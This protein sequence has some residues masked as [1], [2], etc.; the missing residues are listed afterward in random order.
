MVTLWTP[1][2]RST[3]GVVEPTKDS[4]TL[5]NR[6]NVFIRHL[7]NEKKSQESVTGSLG[8]SDLK[9]II[10]LIFTSLRWLIKTVSFDLARASALFDSSSKNIQSRMLDVS[11]ALEAENIGISKTQQ[12]CLASHIA[13]KKGSFSEIWMIWEDP[14]TYNSNY[15]ISPCACLDPFSAS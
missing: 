6:L 2:G 11:K 4:V 15:V 3:K 1:Q 8:W 5:S 10:E 7:L 9:N 13:P 12:A 14:V